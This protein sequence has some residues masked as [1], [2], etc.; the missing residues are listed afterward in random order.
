MLNKCSLN[1][2]NVHILKLALSLAELEMYETM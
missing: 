2:E 1:A